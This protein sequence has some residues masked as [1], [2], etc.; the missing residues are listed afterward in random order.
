MHF[1]RKIAR[2]IAE[3]IE[4]RCHQR[5]S[6]REF[7]RNR[8]STIDCQK[9]LSSNMGSLEL[10]YRWFLLQGLL[11]IL[12]VRRDELFYYRDITPSY[13]RT[14]LGGM[15]GNKGATV[16]SLKAYGNS[17]CFVNSHLAA[18]DH[19]YYKRVQVR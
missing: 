4:T 17:I 7:R 3:R 12:F 18:H 11:L 9:I 19:G 10:T 1:S 13:V 2:K 6:N 16:V 14:G 5:I 8:I 15:W